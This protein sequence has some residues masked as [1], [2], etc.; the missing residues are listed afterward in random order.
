MS[1]QMLINSKKSAKKAINTCLSESRKSNA[2]DRSHKLVNMVKDR[3]KS[4]TQFTKK[5]VMKPKTPLQRIN[6]KAS[7]CNQS[8][9]GESL[10]NLAKKQFELDQFE[11]K[12]KSFLE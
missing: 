4:S 1:V 7:S 5:N 10:A 9:G 6:S 3:I 12:F 8:E 11:N 2:T